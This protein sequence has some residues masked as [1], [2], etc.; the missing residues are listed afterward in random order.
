M[1]GMGNWTDIA[2]HVSTKPSHECKE[3]Y[4]KYYLNPSVPIEQLFDNIQFDK[5]AVEAI[6]SAEYDSSFSLCFCLLFLLVLLWFG[7]H[8]FVWA[9]V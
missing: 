9:F 2:S 3:H 1:Y 6:N 4:L 5:K 8:F 7:F